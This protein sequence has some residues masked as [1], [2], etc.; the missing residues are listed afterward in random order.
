MK[1]ISH[2]TLSTNGINIHVAEAGEGPLVVLVH[3][4]PELWYS[5]RNQIPVLADAGYHAAAID[6][7]G[8]GLTDAP[9]NIE[10][11]TMK[12]LTADV[13]GVVDALGERQAVVIGHDWG[14]PIA[15]HCALLYPGKFR[16]VIALSVPYIPRSPMPPLQMMKAMFQD[17]FF[18]ILYFQAPGIAEGEFEADP[19]RSLRQFMWGASAE[20]PP[21]RAFAKKKGEPF[22]DNL[23]DPGIRPSWL[24]EEDLDYYANEFKRTGFRGG[25]NRYRCM[26]IDWE[27]LPELAGAQVHQPALFIA[28]EKDPVLT[29]A[30]M[31][32]M[33]IGVP[34]LKKTVV[35]PGCGHW[36]Q[37]EKPEEVNREII[38]FLRALSF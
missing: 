8:Y 10:D 13:A 19:K 36:T 31:D 32:A 29:F 2:R 30:P 7:R 14:A 17:N 20:A 22:F 26:D 5:W 6:V 37:Q 16:A 25:F 18:Y 35:L 11:Y 28:G 21:L 4:F 34:N 3:G 23:P 9:P 27:E 15:W 38:G 33:K 12:L 24:S 1:L